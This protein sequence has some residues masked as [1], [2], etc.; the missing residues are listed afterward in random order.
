[1]ELFARLNQSID[2]EMKGKKVQSI[3]PQEMEDNIIVH[4]E[5]L[6]LAV[7]VKTPEKEDEGVISILRERAIVELHQL[8]P[9][10]MPLQYIPSEVAFQRM[11]KEQ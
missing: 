7:N 11:A 3:I 5:S 1:M 4:G 9:K 6:L 8:T 10:K 2:S